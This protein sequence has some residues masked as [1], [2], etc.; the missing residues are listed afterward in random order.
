MIAYPFDCSLIIPTRDRAAVLRDTLRRIHALPDP[1]FEI[2]VVDNGSTDGTDSLQADYPRVRWIR[3]GVNLGCSARNLAAVAARGRLLFMLDDDSW[4]EPGTIDRVV[5]RFDERPDLGAVAC[6]VRLADPPHRHDAGGVPG[7]IFNCGGTIRREAFLAVGGYPIDYDYYVEEYDLSCRL[8]RAGWKIEPHGDLLVWHRR[9][10][11]NRDNDRMLRLLVRNNLRLWSRYAPE[12][13]RQ[14]LLEQ[15]HERYER[16]ALKENALRGYREGVEAGR[17]AAVEALRRCRPLSMRQFE[18]LFGLDHAQDLLRAWAD[19]LRIRSIA[20]WRRQKGCEQLIDLA[21]RLNIFIEAV[22]D[23]AAQSDS[24]RGLP[25]RRESDFTPCHADGIL[26]GSLSPG[27]AEDDAHDL[28]SRFPDYPV[29]SAAPWR[30]VSAQDHPAA[31][32]PSPAP[33]SVRFPSAVSAVSVAR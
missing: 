14:D 33:A 32:H 19:K 12:Q 1:R 27:V 10:R 28:A 26:V 21:R 3:P 20:I 13:L 22:Y 23:D 15:T 9:V 16:V 5:R 18:S 2:I 4:P 30:Y 11:Q 6:R 24:W 25:L 29:H 7:I 8:L 17:R 31:T